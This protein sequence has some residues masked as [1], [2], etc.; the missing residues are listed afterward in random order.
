M[1]VP[2][3]PQ[4]ECKWR[5]QTRQAGPGRLGRC[6]FTRELLLLPDLSTSSFVPAFYP[7]LTPDCAPVLSVS[8]RYLW[9]SVYFYTCVDVEASFIALSVVTSIGPS[10]TILH[11][12]C[13][14]YCL[15]ILFTGHL[16]LIDHAAQNHTPKGF[17]PEPKRFKNEMMTTPKYQRK[18][19]TRQQ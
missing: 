9:T 8:V 13:Q 6:K 1:E 12:I 15:C 3:V 10:L 11:H 2:F 16:I 14:L 19:K 5:D 4:Q 18:A 7:L 17:S